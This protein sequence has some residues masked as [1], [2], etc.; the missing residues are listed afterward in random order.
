MKQNVVNW[1]TCISDL[2][3]ERQSL[4]GNVDVVKTLFIQV[5]IRTEF[6]K[7][8]KMNL[9]QVNSVFQKSIIEVGLWGSQ[10]SSSSCH[11][12]GPTALQCGYLCCHNF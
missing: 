3:I 9:I 6:F 10:F 4:Q 5:S 8:K 1:G 2:G 12:F 7:E 11:C